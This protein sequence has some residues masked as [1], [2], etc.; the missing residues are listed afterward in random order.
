MIRRVVVD[1]KLVRRIISIDEIT[2]ANRITRIFE[3]DAKNDKFRMRKLDESIK[4]RRIA[5]MYSYDITELME[6]INRRIKILYWINTNNIRDFRG[7]TEIL[8]RYRNNPEVFTEKI[9]TQ[10]KDLYGDGY[11][12]QRLYEF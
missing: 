10:L 11:N 2:D 12:V 9:T 1:N 7:I 6:E 3:W 4:L 5:E 8:L